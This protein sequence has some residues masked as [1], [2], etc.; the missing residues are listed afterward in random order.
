MVAVEILLQVFIIFVAAKVAG[1]V[2]LRLGVPVVVGELLVGVAIGPYALGWAGT[3]G[4]GLVAVFHDERLATEVLHGALDVL[5][6]LG[7]VILLFV[8]GLETHLHDVLRVGGRAAAV[9]LGGVLLPLALGYG[10]GLAVGETWASALFLGA[11][12]VATSVGITARVLGEMGQLRTTA[13]RIV[14]GAAVIDDV[15]G[16]LVLSIVAGLVQGGLSLLGVAILA[17]EAAGFTAFVALVGRHVIRQYDVHLERL[18]LPDASFAVALAVCLGLAALAGLV[19]LAGIIGAFLAGV[20]FAEARDHESLERQA[21]TLYDVLVPFFFVV[22]GMRVD[23]ALLAQPQI[24]IFAGVVALLAVVGKVVGC[25]L[26]SLGL[27]GRTIAV[28]AVG[29]VP[30]GEVGLV[31]AGIGRSAGAISDA[32]FAVIA[33]MSIVT[34]LIVPPVL[35]RLLRPPKEPPGASG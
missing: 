19:G 5:A 23:P 24:A 33:I 20:I 1:E 2:A 8:V 7:V 28:V 11:A 18:R 27:D 35:S 14:L 4:A 6:Q 29:M 31:V 9:A 30:R 25:G 32:V 26:A 10:F 13:A 15:L 16:I 22:S 34:A 21:H 3:P 17:A 12:L